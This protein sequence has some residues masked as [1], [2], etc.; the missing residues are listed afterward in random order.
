[1]LDFPIVWRGTS[2]MYG[3]HV[4]NANTLRKAILDKDLRSVSFDLHFTLVTS[5]KSRF[6]HIY[7]AFCETLA[8]HGFS[9]IVEKL[10]N[11]YGR[12]EALNL[13]NDASQSFYDHLHEACEE[14]VEWDSVWRWRQT[15]GNVL[16][17]LLERYEPEAT[18]AHGGNDRILFRM[19]ADPFQTTLGRVVPELVKRMADEVRIRI[20]GSEPD[21]WRAGKTEIEIVG[22]AFERKLDIFIWSNG[23]QDSVEACAKRWYPRIQ[24]QRVFTPGRLAGTGKPSWQATAMFWFNLHVAKLDSVLPEDEWERQ[25][26]EATQKLFRSLKTIKLARRDVHRAYQEWRERFGW[27]RGRLARGYTHLHVGNSDYHDDTLFI[28]DDPSFWRAI[29]EANPA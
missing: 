18:S 23:T 24:R 12:T 17:A 3:A 14:S 13:V 9:E 22:L 1:M 6:E 29:Y 28:G 5:R 7:Q 20:S 16:E 2:P 15:N 26:E 21:D 25:R 8:S 27:P 11:E 10:E 19:F 4:L